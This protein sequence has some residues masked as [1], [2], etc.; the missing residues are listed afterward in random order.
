MCHPR[1]GSTHSG[2]A[3]ETVLLSALFVHAGPE[4]ENVNYSLNSGYIALT[5]SPC[6][7]DFFFTC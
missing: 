6:I 4:L 1:V 5:F 2:D 7:V 3:I